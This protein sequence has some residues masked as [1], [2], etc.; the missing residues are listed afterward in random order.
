MT[1]PLQ[2]L[3]AALSGR[4]RVERELGAG[5]MATVYLAHDLKHERDVAIKVLHPDLGTALGAERFLS[6]IRTT[7]RLQHPHILPLLDSGAAD[8]LLYYVMPYVRGETLRA[9]LEREKQLPIAD[10]VRIAREVA[11]ALDHAHKQGVI[12]R[13]IKPENILLQDGAAVVADFGI[14]LAVQQAGGQRMTQTGLSLGTPQYMSPEQA[15]GERTIDARS[16]IYALGAVT[17]EMLTGEPPFTG[18]SVQAIVARVLT[19][20]PTSITTF[21]DMVS[22][23]VERA[24][25]SA[26]AKLP[27]D[28]PPTAAL[29]ANA[30]APSETSASAVP[31]VAVPQAGKSRRARVAAAIAVVG[32]IGAGGWWSGRATAPEAARWSRF[33]QLTDASGVETSPAIAPDGESFAYASDARGSMDIY[34]QRVGG[35]AAQRVAGDSAVDETSPAWSAD[36]RRLAFARRGDGVWVMESGGENAR[37]VSAVGAMPAWSPDGTQLAFGS[38]EVLNPYNLEDGDVWIAA[39][40]GGTPRRVPITG[41]QRAYQP[42]WSP[43]GERI[44]F[45]T[46]NGGRRDIATV[47]VTGGAAVFVTQDAAVDW[48]PTWSADGRW[49]FFASDRGGAMGL[50]RIAID[51]V[52]GAVHGQPELIAA[53]GDAWFDLPSISRDGRRLLFRSKLES[54]NPTAVDFDVDGARLGASRQLQHRSSGELVPSDISPDGRTLSLTTPLEGRQKLWLM[55]ADGS[56]LRQLTDDPSFDRW[57]R[58]TPD[59]DALVFYSN[60][61]GDWG[62]YRIAP[63]GSGLTRLLT[64]V[65]GGVY[66]PS[67]SPTGRGVLVV[68][69]SG[70][71]LIS[72]PWPAT[73]ARSTPLGPPSMKGEKINTTAWSPD[74]RWITGYLNAVGGERRGHVVVDAQTGEARVL[75]DDSDGFRVAWLPDARRVLYFLRNGS[76]VLQDVVTLARVPVTGSLPAPPEVFGSLVLSRDGRTLYYAAHR[77]EANLWMVEREDSR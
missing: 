44:A 56:Q 16:D 31:S 34:V 62:A 73:F 40:S 28:R 53:G 20:K 52:S 27:A 58:F 36:G 63:D 55:Q 64:N 72:P 18:A 6:E 38:H 65:P 24:V 2:R 9:R 47:S 51:E 57:P 77:I 32:A 3:T 39:V 26:L 70:P 71:R 67:V 4:Y 61:D 14:A 8:G 59:G 19:E 45:F 17:Y 66:W 75:N 74:G 30:L 49:L 23:P 15:M 33:T 41:V 54:A 68:T 37:R 25:L 21:R 7:A 60:R 43:S 12:H 10:A 1:S 5:G 35:R 69:D 11:G 48:A 46:N 42:S 13:D 22:P 29:F 76:L 50:W